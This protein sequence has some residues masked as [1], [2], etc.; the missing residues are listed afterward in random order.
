MCSFI[1]FGHI[2]LKGKKQDF[3]IKITLRSLTLTLQYQQ[4][5]SGDDDTA[6]NDLTMQYQAELTGDDDTAE[7][8]SDSAVSTLILQ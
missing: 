7:T 5:P 1:G 4:Q 2:S 8:D 3:E 6:E